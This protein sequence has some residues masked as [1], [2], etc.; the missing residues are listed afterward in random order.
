[1][2]YSRAQARLFSYPGRQAD[3]I[4]FQMGLNLAAHDD[5]PRVIGMML[6]IAEFSMA[7]LSA[8][9]A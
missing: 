5:Y 9:E 7:H 8:D 3:Y 2:I 4:V 6:L 1:V